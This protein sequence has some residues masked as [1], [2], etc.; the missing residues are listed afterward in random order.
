MVSKKGKEVKKKR[1]IIK[2]ELIFFGLLAVVFVLFS[3]WW[4][5]GPVETRVIDVNF[6]VGDSLGVVVGEDLDFGR[7]FRGSSS[8][9]IVNLE[10]GH[11]F[12]LMVRVLVG[13][14]V[15]DFIFVEPEIILQ[16]GENYGL[17]VNLG[18]PED[19]EFGSY[20]GKMK[21][22]FREFEG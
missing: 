14:G 13:E 18:L 11:D 21:L 19:I 12:P 7:V 2:R 22:E 16:L 9:K 8:T 20:S 10:N 17:H 6:E 15:R 5:S 4:F 1:D 3:Y